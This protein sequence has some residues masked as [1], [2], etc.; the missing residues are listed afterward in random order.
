[1]AYINGN[2]ILNVNVTMGSGDYKEGY[3]NGY[4][5]GYESGYDE[6]FDE[7]YDEGYEDGEPNIDIDED[8]LNKVEVSGT[9]YV[10]AENV[11]GISHPLSV[12][13]TSDTITDFSGITVCRSGRNLVRYPYVDGNVTKDGITFTDK[14]NGIVNISGDANGEENA[15]Y[16]FA[17]EFP[18][19]KGT[20]TL[21]ANCDGNHNGTF[22]YYV[23]DM[24]QKKAIST[25][26]CHKATNNVNTTFTIDEDIEKVYV[27]VLLAS[28]NT[29]VNADVSVQLEYG[30]EASPF[31]LFDG[32]TT[33]LVNAD[34]TVDGLMSICPT[35]VLCADD[36]T[37]DISMSYYK[38][39]GNGEETDDRYDEGYEDGKN[40]VVNL[41]DYCTQIRFVNL[42]R[43]G[44]PEVTLNLPEVTSVDYLCQ[45][46]KT[47]ADGN[48]TVEHI[49]I[50]CPYQVASAR[51]LFGADSG[52]IYDTKLKRITLN[53]DTSKCTGFY[54]AFKNLRALE[55]IDGK[56]LDCSSIGSTGTYTSLNGT[57]D[58]AYKLREVRFAK[59]TI[60][61]SI[62]FS[63]S[64]LLSNETK[65]SIFDGLAQIDTAQT[66]TFH[67]DCKILQSQWDDAKAKGWTV[68]GGTV[69]SEEEYYG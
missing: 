45:M 36:D 67:T 56:P 58:F 17:R 2:K 50:N 19:K 66:I 57:F 69:V 23:Y 54:N 42:N 47:Q 59:N 8:Y 7:G 26:K 27:K 41:G 68:A 55:V 11:L 9:G 43:F 10:V 15:E 53:V 13:L 65:Q 21:S 25:V 44:T 61:R 1:M 33:H 16:I 51:C 4:N 12:K 52:N 32:Y 60:K 29:T 35:T 46:P 39:E 18:L 31:E 30:T 63:G 48:T 49:T 34:G 5:S 24:V 14:G 28:S 6:G 20:Y 62:S 37:V 22:T 38:N 64:N 3:D 40:S